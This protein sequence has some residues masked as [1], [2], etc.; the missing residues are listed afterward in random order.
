MIEAYD[1]MYYWQELRYGIE[2]LI[3][4]LDEYRTECMSDPF[5]D[6]P[7]FDRLE[8]LLNEYVM[9]YIDG[10]M[11]ELD[12]DKVRARVYNDEARQIAQ[13]ALS[14]GINYFGLSHL[15]PEEKPRA[16]EYITEHG[17]ASMSY[18]KTRQAAQEFRKED[19]QAMLKRHGRD[20][21]VLILSR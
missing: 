7:E 2:H 6:T 12:P 17:L 1:E 8:D 11:H 5:E 18:D 13:E 20:C 21:K 4:Q 14:R 10:R 3:G 9:E 15:L 19:L 16:I